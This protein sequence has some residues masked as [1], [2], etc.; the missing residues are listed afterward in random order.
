MSGITYAN[1]TLTITY[2]NGLTTAIDLSAIITDTNLEEL[3]NIAVS[4]VADGEV[5]TWNAASQKWINKAIDLASV[6]TSANAYTDEQIA[7]INK[8]GALAVDEKP[9]YDASGE[10]PKIVYIQ[11]GESK[12]TTNFNT[13]FYYTDSDTSKMMQT[14]WIEGVEF[15][16]A[17]ANEVDFSDFVQV[18]NLVSTYSGTETDKTKIPTIAALDSLKAIIDNDLGTKVNTADVVD[19]LLSESTDMPL[20]AN[21][22]RILNNTKLANTTNASNAGK[23]VFADNDGNLVFQSVSDNLS[24]LNETEV[25]NIFRQGE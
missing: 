6:L 1:K 17:V 16:L 14:I 8:A 15:T 7:K 20:S 25:R 4:S 19:N 10:K 21:Q 22:G 11:D 24:Y 9:I 18:I 12:E 2:R 13:W 5:L 23:A 3:K